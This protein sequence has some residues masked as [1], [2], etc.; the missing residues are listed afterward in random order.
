MTPRWWRLGV[1]VEREGAPWTMTFHARARSEAGARR[2]VA[3]R[4][5]GE[6]HAVYACRKSEPIP[7]LPREEDVAAVFGPYRRSWDDPAVA[8]LRG[9]LGA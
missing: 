4:L 1:L 5:P 8:K 7:K 9:L 3:E 6:R 2:L